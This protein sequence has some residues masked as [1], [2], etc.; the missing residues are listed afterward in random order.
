MLTTENVVFL[1][2]VDNT[3]LDND[4]FGADLSA[5]L[6]D[7]F[8]D[9][10]RQRYWSIYDTRREQ[11]GYAD[12]LGALQEFRTGRDNVPAMLRMSDFLLDYPFR[13]RLY[14]RAT[15]A[16]E[17]LRTL[18]STVIL[19]DGDIVLQPRK[20]QCAGLWEAVEDRVLVYVHK[21]RMLDEVRRR[22][23]AQHYVVIDDKPQLLAT[24]KRVLADR[25]T[26]VFV[27]QGHYAAESVHIA[28][29][30]APDLTIE[31][32]GDLC[33]FSLADFHAVEMPCGM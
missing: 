6:D 30:P 26:T 21:E 3:L 4:C 2:D 9:A 5:H 8:G 12:Y 33:D 15:A 31:R 29:L 27:R 28:V 24:M 18:G 1:I 13:E 32:I 16:I 14:P 25:S 22:F 23:P 19:S 20:I 7:D 17:H 10:E 11:L